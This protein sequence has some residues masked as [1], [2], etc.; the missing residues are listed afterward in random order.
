MEER[1][2][3]QELEN[4]KSAIRRDHSRR[5]AEM[6]ASVEEQLSDIVISKRMKVEKEVE[7]IREEQRK[8]YRFELRRQQSYMERQVRKL[9]M[10]IHSDILKDLEE[11]MRQKIQNLKQDHDNYNIVLERLISEGAAVLDQPFVLHLMKEDMEFLTCKYDALKIEAIETDMWGGC[12][13]EV[14]IPK[15]IFVDNTLKTR[16]I[17]LLPDL[18][19][20]LTHDIDQFLG[21]T[22]QKFTRKLRLS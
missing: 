10:E 18:S 11:D 16:W 22:I 6:K 20:R 4:F 8:R 15:N 7:R 19:E 5:L 13:L 3:E 21:P 9:L 12:I 17:R 2:Q 14:P 1:H